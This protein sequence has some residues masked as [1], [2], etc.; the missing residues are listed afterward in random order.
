MEQVTLE[1]AMQIAFAH[2]QA[3]R[4][5]ESEIICREILRQYPDDP[6]AWHLLG[7]IAF[8]TANL[9]IA[10]TLIRRAI[11]IAPDFA[12]AHCDLGIVLHTLGKYDPAIASFRESLRLD[13]HNPPAHWNLG[14]A[15]L[16][17]RPVARR[18][19]GI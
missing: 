4:L 9:E 14:T 15:L 2:Q 18:L 7:L 8:Q 6:N 13:P 10:Q 11:E 16:A 1:Q 12:V 19:A 3:G 17:E 5:A